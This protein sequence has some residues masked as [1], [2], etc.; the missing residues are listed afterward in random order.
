[1][2]EGTHRSFK[3]SGIQEMKSANKGM[4]IF[5]LCRTRRQKRT[6]I[7]I[8]IKNIITNKTP[9]KRWI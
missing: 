9:E 5:G 1:V 3:V 6:Q 7:L 2:S 4:P 8:I